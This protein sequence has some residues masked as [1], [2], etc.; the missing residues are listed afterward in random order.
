MEIPT[1]RP[2][3]AFADWVPTTRLPRSTS[4][5]P[6]SARMSPRAGAGTTPCRPSSIAAFRARGRSWRSSATARRSARCACSAADGPAPRR[7]L[8]PAAMAAAGP[9]DA[10]PAPLPVA[11]RRR[12]AAG[13]L[14]HLAWNPVGSLY[15]RHGFAE[16]GRDDTFVYMDGRPPVA[17]ARRVTATLGRRPDHPV[18]GALA[19]AA[20]DAEPARPSFHSSAERSSASLCAMCRHGWIPRRGTRCACPASKPSAR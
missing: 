10:H 11:G 2:T 9:R 6:R 12:A 1:C 13:R 20:D 19:D 15:R 5:R 14:Q 7:V 8:S 3:S 16:T 17:S 18:I 4:R